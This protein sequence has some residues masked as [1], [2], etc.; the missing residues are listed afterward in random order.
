M[1]EKRRLST[2]VR[3][4]AGIVCA[5]L[6]VLAASP[7]Q[8][9]NEVQVY[10]IANFGGSNQCGNSDMTH[11]V[12][13]ETAA[14]FRA[15]F[16]MYKLA[17]LWDETATLNNSNAKGSLFQDAS[18]K[19]SG[20]D[21]TA[22]AGGDEADVIYVHT[23]GGHT[24]PTYD[25]SVFPPKASGPAYS[26]LSMG[27]AS[28]ACSVRTDSDML[29]GNTG[30]DLDIAVIKACQSGDYG[31]WKF[32]G[33]SS[34]KT[35][36]SSLTMW[37]AFHGD[38]SCGGHVTDYVGDY[39]ATSMNNGVGENWIDEAYDGAFWPWEDDDC[40]VSIVWGSSKTAR[41]NMYENGGFRD[42]KDTGTKSGSTYF[43]VAGCDPDHG[44]KL[45][46]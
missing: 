31:V 39:A 16:D 3:G 22:N 2:L 40:P 27:N 14:T 13:T 9:A 41:K 32:G 36:T 8:A 21:T 1:F 12:H 18:K 38:S 23:H 44:S 30:G 25:L 15:T 43:Y 20:A 28:F 26:S 46:E 7:A 19:A 10:G 45:P 17:M 29:W 24:G 34:M 4:G 42:R 6:A 35:S 11:S 33:Y 5:A 37:N